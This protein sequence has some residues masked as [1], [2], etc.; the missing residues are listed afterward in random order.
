MQKYL[1]PRLLQ[2]QKHLFMC[3]MLPKVSTTLCTLKTCQF[4]FLINQFVAQ[5]LLSD[6]VP[7]LPKP[8]FSVVPRESANGPSSCLSHLL[9]KNE[10]GTMTPVE[11]IDGAFN[12][13]EGDV[14]K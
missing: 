9:I 5:I 3:T 13:F 2:L 1:R 14:Y 7:P 6:S 11:L 4:A 10:D 12:Y 8:E